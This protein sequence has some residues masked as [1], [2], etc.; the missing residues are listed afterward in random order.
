MM[1]IRSLKAYFTLLGISVTRR[2]DGLLNFGHLRQQNFHNT[3]KTTTL[4][5]K[6]SK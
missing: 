2:L 4:S 3:I 5:S 1:L 6:I